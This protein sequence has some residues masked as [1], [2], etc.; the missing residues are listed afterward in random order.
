MSI[1]LILL[2]SHDITE[3]L[4]VNILST[5]ITI[6]MRVTIRMMQLNLRTQINFKHNIIK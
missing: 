4:K 3:P 5:M 2:Q 6:I 1:L